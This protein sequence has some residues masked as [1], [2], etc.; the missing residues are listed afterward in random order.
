MKSSRREMLI[1]NRKRKEERH[2][3]LDNI[4]LIHMEI[5]WRGK[6]KP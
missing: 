5:M 6:E 2:W 3:E 4:S 1:F